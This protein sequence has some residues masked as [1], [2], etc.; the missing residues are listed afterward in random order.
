MFPS[1]RNDSNS[2]CSNNSKGKK[3]EKCMNIFDLPALYITEG[4]S[5]RVLEN[6]R[7]NQEF[8]RKRLISRINLFRFIHGNNFLRDKWTV[9]IL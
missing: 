9:L 7:K 8:R 5:E 2:Y 6:R 4:K 1:N 3:I